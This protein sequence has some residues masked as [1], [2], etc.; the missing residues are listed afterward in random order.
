MEYSVAYAVIVM[1]KGHVA[2][3]L[4]GSVP[5]SRG[6]KGGGKLIRAAEQGEAESDTAP[7][8]LIAQA[9]LCHVEHNR[10]REA[11]APEPTTTRVRSTR[12]VRSA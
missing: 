7:S 1:C 6:D 8:S 5:G 9:L 12:R 3:W 2:A 4:G 11:A 10:V